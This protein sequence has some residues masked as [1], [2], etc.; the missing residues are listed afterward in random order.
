M[1]T[2]EKRKK[3]Y[4]NVE[5]FREIVKMIELPEDLDYH[6]ASSD[7]QEVKTY[8]MNIYND[9]NYGGCEGIYLDV[10][11]RYEDEQ[12]K[13]NTIP[14]GTFKTLYTSRDDMRMMALLLADF[15]DA[16]DKFIN[17][18]IHDFE[19]S[20][21]NVYGANEEGEKIDDAYSVTTDTYDHARSLLYSGLLSKYPAILIVDNNTK[22]E[23][24]LK[25]ERTDE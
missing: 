22:K 8:N 5:L 18:H 15:I 7:V 6:L 25:K 16:A 12:H 13:L 3:P 1:K 4:T 23:T 2:Q 20:G 19:W 21:F 10:G 17:S 14:L 9:L 24:V 11:L